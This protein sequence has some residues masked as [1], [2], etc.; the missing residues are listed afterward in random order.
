MTNE[1]T[2]ECRATV[3]DASLKHVPLWS[4]KARRGSPSTANLHRL[5]VAGQDESISSW[6]VAPGLFSK[7][8]GLTFDVLGILEP[9]KVRGEDVDGGHVWLERRGNRVH[10]E[11]GEVSAEALE[12]LDKYW[13]FVSA[14]AR[15]FRLRPDGIHIR[16]EL[17]EVATPGVL[18]ARHD[19]TLFIPDPPQGPLH[20]DPLK[21]LLK[22]LRKLQGISVPSSW[23]VLEF[24]TGEISSSDVGIVVQR[25]TQR[26]LLTPEP[27]RP[28]VLSL[29]TAAVRF[30]LTDQR[31]G[32]PLPPRSRL[33][34]VADDVR[35]EFENGVLKRVLVRQGPVSPA[36]TGDLR[37]MMAWEPGK[38]DTLTLPPSDLAVSSNIAQRLQALRPDGT[39]KRAMMPVAEGWLQLE[40]PSVVDTDVPAETDGGW[41]IGTRRLERQGDNTVEDQLPFA[42]M[43]EGLKA[44]A[45]RVDIDSAP[46]IAVSKLTTTLVCSRFSIRGLLWLG[47]GRADDDD[48]LPRLELGADTLRDLEFTSA[49]TTSGWRVGLAGLTVSQGIGKAW[50]E[51]ACNSIELSRLGEPV[52]LWTRHPDLPAISVMPLTAARDAAPRALASRELLPMKLTGTAIKL[53]HSTE[54]WPSVLV[55]GNPPSIAFWWPEAGRTSAKPADGA[56]PTYQLPWASLTL[57]GL[58]LWLDGKQSYRIDLP[59]VDERYAAAQPPPQDRAIP[60]APDNAQDACPTDPLSTPPTSDVRRSDLVLGDDEGIQQ[61]FLQRLDAW[62]LALGAHTTLIEPGMSSDSGALLRGY[63]WLGSF[64]AN[65]TANDGLGEILIQDGTFAPGLRGNDALAGLSASPTLVG[66]TIALGPAGNDR[67]LGWALP[68]LKLGDERIDA[69]GTRSSSDDTRIAGPDGDRHHRYTLPKPIVFTCADIRCEF[70]CRELPVQASADG[71]RVF[72]PDAR[73]AA[74]GGYE[75]RLY[76]ANDAATAEHIPLSPHFALAPRRLR[77]FRHAGDR[78]QLR[79]EGELHA[80]HDAAAGSLGVVEVVLDSGLPNEVQSPYSDEKPSPPLHWP[81]R[82]QH[83]ETAI[84]LPRRPWL[85]FHLGTGLSLRQCRVHIPLFGDW[86]A[87]DVEGSPASA[88]QLRFQANQPG[89][90]LELGHKHQLTLS[91]QFASSVVGGTI[92]RDAN[93]NH[94]LELTRFPGLVSGKSALH[95]LSRFELLRDA[96]FGLNWTTQSD[97]SLANAVTLGNANQHWALGMAMS[98]P[99]PAGAASN[100]RVQQVYLEGTVLGDQGSRLDLLWLD[101]RSRPTAKTPSVSS[102]VLRIDM[103]WKLT[104]VVDW[105]RIEPSKPGQHHILRVTSIDRRSTVEIE[106]KGECLVG[107]HLDVDANG[108]LVF[109]PDAWPSVRCVHKLAAANGQAGFEASLYHPV[110]IG[111]AGQFEAS[112]NAQV[113]FKGLFENVPPKSLDGFY[114]DVFCKALKAHAT[115]GVIAAMP[116]LLLDQQPI[117]FPVLVASGAAATALR[118]ALGYSATTL[119][120]GPGPTFDSIPVKIDRLDPVSVTLD[121]RAP[122]FRHRVS[123]AWATLQALR[124]QSFEPL[125]DHKV[126][127]DQRFWPSETWKPEN[128]PLLRSQAWLSQVLD[129]KKTPV[130]ILALAAQQGRWML[131]DPATLVTRTQAASVFASTAPTA[132]LVVGGRDSV[133]ILP[134]RNHADE[135]WLSDSIATLHGAPAFAFKRTMS[136]EQIVMRLE[137]I[138][139]ATV[140]VGLHAPGAGVPGSTM[141]VHR[142]PARPP[143]RTAEGELLAETIRTEL[144]DRRPIDLPEQA[145]RGTRHL[146]RSALATDIDLRHRSV[147]D[148]A[149]AAMRPNAQAYRDLRETL[150]AVMTATAAPPQTVP[151]DPEAPAEQAGPMTPVLYPYRESIVIA[152]RSGVLRHR[153]ESIAQ[154]DGG[155]LHEHGRS[156]AHAL[157]APRPLSLPPERQCRGLWPTAS[158]VDAVRGVADVTFLP[159]LGSGTGPMRV[160]RVKLADSILPASWR[161]DLWLRVEQAEFPSWLPDISVPTNAAWQG[162]LQL[163]DQVLPLVVEPHRGTSAPAATELRIALQPNVELSSDDAQRQGLIRLSFAKQENRLLVEPAATIEL[164]IVVASRRR[165]NLPM[166]AHTLSFVDPVYNDGLVSR[167]AEHKSGP[168]SAPMTLYADRLSYDAQAS[169]VLMCSAQATLALERLRPGSARADTL[170]LGKP[171]QDLALAARTPVRIELAA[172]RIADRPDQAA[173][174]AG[175]ILRVRAGTSQLLLPIAAAPVLTPPDAAYALLRRHAGKVRCASYGVGVMPDRVVLVDPVADLT[176]GRVRRIAIFRWHVVLPCWESDV[177]YFIQRIDHTGATS[178][179]AI[180]DF[181]VPT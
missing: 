66:R 22:Q 41:E 91:V 20:T 79:V 171:A 51:L 84:D 154:Y 150:P 176:S 104:S 117:V 151:A 137:A 5:V 63:D 10:L 42:F 130:A 19:E 175:D 122:Q 46:N 144:L 128:W 59:Y 139:L 96:G 161:G 30:E 142:G 120:T 28:L 172:L 168:D 58:E 34:L 17:G 160:T 11:R 89:L 70:W 50:P 69:D 180:S 179:P 157:R 40:L 140:P 162:V 36:G 25:N 87:L 4:F 90:V 163:G 149:Y 57:P 132:D 85:R 73:A 156:L 44:F 159:D 2:V 109:I 78:V 115:T 125:P 110:F 68:M 65:M 152:Q 134:G 145:A 3:K 95:A 106:W 55:E 173:L 62:K 100:A 121:A 27:K 45:V 98:F 12:A 9:I 105:P 88:T 111:T 52:V 86:Q 77:Q 131:Y 76:R 75:W 102:F 136:A 53:K 107:S 72:D 26:D 61:M 56:K 103:T 82:L 108:A 74:L 164:P 135:R 165:F 92:K 64:S 81:I 29:P 123:P 83:G 129:T 99:G 119:Q 114:S 133:G 112:L 21:D 141:S 43:A 101:D 47:V 48:L 7:P 167:V 155:R 97:F 18:T 67:M 14:P 126:V 23:G 166:Q 113:A 118:A 39:L 178:I 8:A 80:V 49:A 13:K 170:V 33:P 153:R 6:A 169:M 54:A 60:P 116:L 181:A 37:L 147:E 124:S 1:V 94:T 143:E 24:F 35:A 148:V 174:S 38:G 127:L 32:S 158:S 138:P 146:Y 16:A 31:R 71:A 93:G 15:A 177:H